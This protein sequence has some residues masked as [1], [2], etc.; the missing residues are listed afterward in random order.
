[1]KWML[2]HLFWIGVGLI[3]IAGAGLFVYEQIRIEQAAS[4]LANDSS[5]VESAMSGADVVKGDSPANQTKRNPLEGYTVAADRPRALYIDSLQIA[6][7]I[8]PVGLTGKSIQAPTN[9]YDSGWYTGSAKP[10]QAGAMFIDGHASG[11]TRLGLFAY[12]DTLKAGDKIRVEKGDGE[13]V[14]Y[15]V[16]AVEIV[17]KDA[18]KM[19]KVLSPYGASEKGLNLMA[20]TGTWIEA[21][22]TYDKRVTVYTEQ[23]E[24]R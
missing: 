19:K 12:L 9:I 17:S 7:R 1:M 8:I 11:S 5:Q 6:A 18:V 4:R 24:K 22:K 13:M 16:K 14:H 23:V 15:E 21:E 2:S 10:D 3:I 20:C